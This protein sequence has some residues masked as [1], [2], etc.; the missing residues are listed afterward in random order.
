MQI[1]APLLAVSVFSFIFVNNRFCAFLEFSFCIISYRLPSR[2]CE[3]KVFILLIPPDHMILSPPHPTFHHGSQFDIQCLLLES[4][5]KQVL[6]Q[7]SNTFRLPFL[8]Y[9]VFPRANNCLILFYVLTNSIPNTMP[10]VSIESGVL[11]VLSS[12]KKYHLELFTIWNGCFYAWC[13][14]TSL[15]NPRIHP[16]GDPYCLSSV[17][18]LSPV[19]CGSFLMFVYHDI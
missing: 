19:S 1:I 2:T 8:N 14:A 13:M 9:A 3:G 12:W 6:T 10:I 11:S 4:C 5:K 16:L 18:L 15:K 7:P 17:D